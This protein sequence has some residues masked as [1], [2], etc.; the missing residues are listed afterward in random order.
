[1]TAAQQAE[2]DVEVRAYARQVRAALADVP[3]HRLAEL[4]DDLEEHL[5]EVA[6]EGGEPLIVRLGPPAGYAAELRRAAGLPEPSGAPADPR[7]PLR[8]ELADAVA[9]LQATPA[10]RAVEEFLPELRPAWWVLRA[11]GALVAADALLTGSSSF[12]VPTF[13]TSVLVGL[14]LTG[15]AVTWSV[16]RGQRV[17]HDP[18]LA[19]ERLAV[20]ANGAL[21]LLALIAVFGAGGTPEPAMAY[22]SD[23]DPDDATLAHEDGT[24][25]TNIHPYS[26]TGEPLEDVLLYDQDGR[27]ID[28]LATYTADGGEVQRLELGHPAPANAFPQQQ[29]VVVYDVY[30]N[31]TPIEPDAAGNDADDDTPAPPAPPAPAVPATP[32]AEPEAEPVP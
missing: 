13:G 30:G 9:R 29:R 2:P 17:R 20:L 10:Y 16:R 15:A 22:Y 1:M 26:A 27:P 14:V 28:N 3:P 12:P 31:P 18:G 4:L 25:I 24:P 19:H 32:T 7:P 6:S 5:V 23:P 8:G 21:A 11:W